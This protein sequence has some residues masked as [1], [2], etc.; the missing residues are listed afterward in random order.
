MQDL[1]GSVL[2][3][4]DHGAKLT[5]DQLAEALYEGTPHLQNLAEKLARHHGQAQALSFYGLMGDDVRNFWRGIAKQLIDHAAEWEKNLGSS[6]VLSE[7]EQ[8]RLKALPR[9]PLTAGTTTV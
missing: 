2:K 1:A 6:C 9:V 5:I 7:Q 8:A 3:V 4:R